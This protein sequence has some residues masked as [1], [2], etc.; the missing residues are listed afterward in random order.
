[1]TGGVAR[2]DLVRQDLVRHDLVRVAPAA[3]AGMLAARP[4]L[5][6]VP[7]LAGWAEAGRPLIVRRFGP[8]EDRD[9]VALGL[10][11]PPADGKRRIG[12][13]CAAHDLTPVVPP[14]LRAVRSAA[15]PDWRPTLDALA[16]LGDRLG[17]VPRPFGGLLWQALTGL[18]YLGASSDL[19]LLW[20]VAA[21]VPGALLDGIA[22]IAAHAPMRIDGE[23]LLPD[24]MGVHWRELHEAPACG[25][26]LAK[27]RDRLALVPAASLR[28]AVAA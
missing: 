4:D 22:G 14:T 15:P 21:P 16:T 20:P 28:G 1:M 7:P 6:P 12:L 11:L 5:G 9:R 26:V 24:G 17:L 8:G 3:W 19:D 10:P 23:V 27:H 25:E 2:Q 18:A 13:M